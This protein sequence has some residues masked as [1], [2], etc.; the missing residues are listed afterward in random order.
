MVSK[1]NLKWTCFEHGLLLKLVKAEQPCRTSINKDDGY[2][3]SKCKKKN[4]DK[5]PRITGKNNT[6]L[7]R[8]VI[9]LTT[10]FLL[11]LVSCLQDFDL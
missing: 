6:V 5:T 10:F 7:A 3:N 4:K 9:A 1:F 11:I 8:K 2:Q